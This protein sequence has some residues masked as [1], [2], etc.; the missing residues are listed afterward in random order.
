MSRLEA[1]S[2]QDPISLPPRMKAALEQ[3]R[4]RVWVIKLAEGALTAIFGLVVSYL[5]V[6][7]LDRL[8]DTPSLLRAA[9]LVTGSVG[10][11]ILFPLKYHNWIWSHRRLDQ[12]ARLVRHE[13]PRFGDHLLGIVELA[14]RDSQQNTSQ[15]LVEAAMWQVDA[16]LEERDLT[17]AV[18]H[19]QHRRWAWAA[20]VPLALCAVVMVVIPAAGS[21]ALVRWLM[22]WRGVERY[23]FAQIDGGAGHRVVPY[24]EP[25]TLQISLREN[26]PWKPDS[27]RARYEGQSPVVATRDGNSYRFDIPPQTTNGNVSVRVGDARR[28]IPVQPITRPALSGLLAEVQLPDYLQRT[29]PLVEGVRGGTVSLVK[30]SSVVFKA[31]AT[32]A[33]AKA[34]LNDHPQSVD[35]S[36]V[37]TQKIVVESS[38][39]YRLAWSDTFGLETRQPLLLQVEAL[40]RYSSNGGILQTEKQP[41]HPVYG[42]ACL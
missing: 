13:Y 30:G 26:S 37:T 10:M 34:T 14:Q 39:E 16:E 2:Q 29:E 19:P 24:A 6:F 36:H 31:E 1:K 15:S 3:Y 11:V 4:K 17:D 20:G 32:R 18:P 41:G 9:M 38:T 22:P 5:F 25:F 33:L 27:G 8:F 40:R 23:T 42:R 21:N 12:V 7:A 35:G 28:T